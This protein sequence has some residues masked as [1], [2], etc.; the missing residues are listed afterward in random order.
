MRETLIS[1]TTEIGIMLPEYRISGGLFCF[2]LLLSP[3]FLSFWGF[4]SA[5]CQTFP[6]VSSVVFLACLPDHDGVFVC[7]SPAGSNGRIRAKDGGA[8]SSN[9]NGGQRGDCEAGVLRSGKVSTQTAGVHKSRR[10]CRYRESPFPRVLDPSYTKTCLFSSLTSASCTHSLGNV[11]QADTIKQL[12]CNLEHV[13][14]WAR[15]DPPEELW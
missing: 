2:E 3:H 6:P 12:F 11:P 10:R 7:F 5:F 8:L 9:G 4:R 14:G 1:D 15:A 13:I